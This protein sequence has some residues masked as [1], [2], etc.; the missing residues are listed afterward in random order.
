MAKKITIE[1]PDWALE[2]D[3]HILAGTEHL[4]TAGFI[5]GTM[6][7]KKARCNMCGVCCMNPPETFI[8]PV[9]DNRCVHL[10]QEGKQLL[11]GL[12]R[13][14]PLQCCINDPIINEDKDIDCPIEYKKVEL[15]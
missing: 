13:F 3:I 2:R 6:C 9:V 8:F 15:Q 14:K 11:C 5:R 12:G 4:A 7:V 10:I 1:I